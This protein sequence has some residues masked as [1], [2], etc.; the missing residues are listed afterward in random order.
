MYGRSG[1]RVCCVGNGASAMQFL[2]SVAKEA[3]SLR[4]FQHS[5]NFLAPVEEYY[6]KVGPATRA[7]YRPS[8]HTHRR[9]SDHSNTNRQLRPQFDRTLSRTPTPA[10]Y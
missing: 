1:K 9:T 2:P 7:A 10:K 6:D 4:V 3:A 5:P 8:G